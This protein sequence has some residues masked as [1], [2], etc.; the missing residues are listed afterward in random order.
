MD[1][2]KETKLKMKI[3]ELKSET[4]LDDEQVKKLFIKNYL[5]DGEEKNSTELFSEFLHGKKEK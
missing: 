3:D 5:L 1:L 4:G 2:S